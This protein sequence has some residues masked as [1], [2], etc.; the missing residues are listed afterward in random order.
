MKRMFNPIAAACLALS[1]STVANTAQAPDIQR[2]V[3]QKSDS[4][5]RT[6]V[7][8]NFFCDRTSLT[9]EQRKRQQEIAM[10][11][12]SSLLGVRELSDGYEFELPFEPGTYQKLAQ[13]TPM[14]H[15]CCPFFDIAIRLEREGGKL[16]WRLTGEEGVKE[17]IRAEFSP[18]FKRQSN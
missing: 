8:T 13:F 2:P 4:N 17:F 3:T 1:A 12:R 9:A 18:W 6:T 7:K 14:E 10:S 16:W 15:S 5:S 11:L